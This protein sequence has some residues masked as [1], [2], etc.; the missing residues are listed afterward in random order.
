MSFTSFLIKK[1]VDNFL[2]W[3]MPRTFIPK[4][5]MVSKVKTY[6]LLAYA[7]GFLFKI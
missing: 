6:R 3:L 5:T 4:Y 1:H 7:G 2:H